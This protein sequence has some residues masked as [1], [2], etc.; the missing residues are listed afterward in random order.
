MKIN[1]THEMATGVGCALSKIKDG[2]VTNG[3]WCIKEEYLKF[4]EDI[5]IAENSSCSVDSILKTIKNA[6]YTD[7]PDFRVSVNPLYMP[8]VSEFNE[9]PNM[10]VCVA[11]PTLPILFLNAE[12]GEIVGFLMPALSREAAEMAYKAKSK[13]ELMFMSNNYKA[14]VEKHDLIPIEY[15][16][17]GDTTP[18]GL[19][20]PR[21]S[22][23]E[24]IK[25]EINRAV[26]HSGG[27]WLGKFTRKPEDKDKMVELISKMFSK[28][29]TVSDIQKR[30]EKLEND[31]L[32]KLSDEE[33]VN[34]IQK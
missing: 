27:R 2:W 12:V 21:N 24:Y 4:P 26:K 31:A 20:L 28:T 17:V 25:K 22:S 18:H 5:L 23:D 13:Q 6:E 10:R 11:S 14:Y 16:L 8:I 15:T 30:A 3:A 29:E 32:S 7:D 34:L 1:I 9:D 33:V 19:M